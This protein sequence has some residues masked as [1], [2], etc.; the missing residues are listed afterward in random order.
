MAMSLGVTGYAQEIR[1]QPI[2]S[3]GPY[4]IDD[5]IGNHGIASEIKIPATGVSI[6]LE[7]KLSGWGSA[8][9]NPALG[10]Y[11]G[12]LVCASY[13]NGVGAALYADC[14]ATCPDPNPCMCHAY[15]DQSRTDFVF[16]DNV[17]VGP[18]MPPTCD[19]EYSST[20]MGG[21]AVDEGLIYYGGTLDVI[22]PSGAKGTYELEWNPAD[23]KTFFNDAVGR[24]IPGLYRTTGKITVITGKCCYD[25][26]PGS[27]MCEDDLTEAEC[28]ALAA[29]RFYFPEQVCE[30]GVGPAHPEDCPTCVDDI[31]CDDYDACTEDHCDVDGSAGYG[32]GRCYRFHLYDPATDCC[33]AADGST[34]PFDDGNDCTADSC[35]FKCTV[36]GNVCTDDSDCDPMDDTD[37]CR[38]TGVVANESLTGT[39][40]VHPIACAIDDECNDGVCEGNLAWDGRPEPLPDNML[41]IACTDTSDCPGD[42]DVQWVCCN[43]AEGCAPADATYGYCTCT[44]GTPLCPQ[45]DDVC[46]GAGDPVYAVLAMGTGS[47]VVTGGQFLMSYDPACIDFVSIGPCANSIFATVID[48]WVNEVDGLIWYAVIA[49]DELTYEMQGTFGPYD[50]ACMEFVKLAGC[51]PCNLCLTSDN[52][53]NTLLTNDLGQSVEIVDPECCSDDIT[54]D[55]EIEVWVPGNVDVNADCGVTYA[56][57]LWDAPYAVD[58]CLGP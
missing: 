35:E 23:T 5:Q 27:T 32:L 34:D 39:L 11:Q 51:E 37:V 8:P 2:S 20:Q 24:K 21:A 57:V 58:E 26:G 31:D 4:T 46:Y 9:G 15:I 25:V 48:W 36:G 29:P 7:I 30:H 44:T 47:Q 54:L 38:G 40:C 10:A 56:E 42:A 3:T 16:Y 19:Y 14:S 41:K 45:F 49:Y 22:V 53:Y 12:T 6:Q 50:L 18:E 33:N 43:E 17:A 1:W 52:P 55:G 28:D 13:A